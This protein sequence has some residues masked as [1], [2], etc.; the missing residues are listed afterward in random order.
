[1]KLF[2]IDING[3]LIP[4]KEYRFKDKGKRFEM[5]GSQSCNVAYTVNRVQNIPK[6][7]GGV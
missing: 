4:Y 7:S 5:N 1:M 6:Y 3:K 2:N